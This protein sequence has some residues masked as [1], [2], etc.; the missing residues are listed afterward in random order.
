MDKPINIVLRYIAIVALP[1]IVIV[2]ANVM[3]HRIAEAEV[4]VLEQDILVYNLEQ[5][6]EITVLEGSKIIR[7]DVPPTLP[8]PT[9]STV[10]APTSTP[11]QEPTIEPQLYARLSHY[12]PA[13]GGT[14][15]H[16]ANWNGTECTTL[17]TDGKQWQHW[18]YWATN[19]NATACPREFKLGTVFAIEGFGEYTCIDRGG[20][21]NILPDATFYLDLLTPDQPYVHKGDIVR[22]KF[23]PS[24]SWVVRVSIV[25]K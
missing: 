15:C 9:V 8:P 12:W 14:N 6:Q 17:L 16:P 23:S 7:V 11:I 21:I 20:A 5:S 25:D 1:T 3:W 13:L 4:E 18:Y 24:G 2:G 19:I 10:L 22:D